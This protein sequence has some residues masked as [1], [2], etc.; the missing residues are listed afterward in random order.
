MIGHVSV[1]LTTLMASGPASAQEI[2]LRNDTNLDD[3]YDPGEAVIWL[4]YPECAISVLT[5][6]PDEYPLEIHTIE[7]FFVSNTGNLQGE[8]GYTELGIQII[9][10]EAAPSGRGSWAWGEEAFLTTASDD[11]LNRLSLVDDENDWEAIT[12]TEGS[13]AVWMCP[14]DP[15]TGADWPYNNNSDVTGIVVDGASPSAH[16]YVFYDD[17]IYKLADLG[18]PGS[19]VIRAV[20]G[21]DT[22]G[23]DGGGE[24]GGGEGGS[25]D[26]GGDGDVFVDS[27]TPSSVM[28]GE[29]TTVAIV[30]E[31]FDED[32]TAFVGGLA[33]S[34]VS[35]SGG[36]A[37]TGTLPSALPAGVHDVLVSNPSGGSD[38]LPAGFTVLSA[39]E[40]DGGGGCGCGGG[41]QGAL[42]L[43]LGPLAWARSRRPR[44]A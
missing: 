6:E 10:E 23:S 14:T 4:E 12:L 37:L 42:L 33:V 7:F 40:V 28:E 43:L 22:G 31:G 24:D 44:R 34:S 17:A 2:V 3:T 13:L 19:W 11:S 25:G 32:A 9:D 20:A 18:V 26:D 41:S 30:G 39:E 16:N 1:L 29:S 27:I 5:P 38:T 36:N 35:V 8:S 15:V 21:E